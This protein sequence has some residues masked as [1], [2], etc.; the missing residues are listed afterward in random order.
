MVQLDLPTSHEKSSHGI[1]DNRGRWRA[2]FPRRIL[3]QDDVGGEVEALERETVV[4]GGEW[5]KIIC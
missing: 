5:P 3:S 4:G 2:D 1:A